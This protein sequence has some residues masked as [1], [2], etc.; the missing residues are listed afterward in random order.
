LPGISN[1]KYIIKY[2]IKDEMP[3]KGIFFWLK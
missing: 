3:L 1:I 2:S